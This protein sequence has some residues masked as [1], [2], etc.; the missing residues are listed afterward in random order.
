M[1]LFKTTNK[2]AFHPGSQVKLFHWKMSHGE[3][4]ITEVIRYIIIYAF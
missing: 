3:V 1:S 4:S 2:I